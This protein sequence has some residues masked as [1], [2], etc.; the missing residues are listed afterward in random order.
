MGGFLST[1]QKELTK[2]NDEMEKMTDELLKSLFKRV[3]ESLDTFYEQISNSAHDAKLLPI[4]RV[5]SK[6]IFVRAVTAT[7][8]QDTI[9]NIVDSLVDTFDKGPSAKGIGQIAKGVVS[10][11]MGKSKGE[12]VRDQTYACRLNEVNGLS[13]LDVLFLAYNTESAS[14]VQRTSTVIGCCVVS[15]SVDMKGL[16][17]NTLR[18]VTGECFGSLPRAHQ[19]LIFADFYWKV[20]RKTD[21]KP[22]T[23]EEKEERKTAMDKIEAAYTE[24]DKEIAEKKKAIE[25][26]KP[27]PPA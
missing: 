26:A 2:P 23:D 25:A 18:V 15:S 9:G 24:W 13:R 5:V 20:M 6:K 17:D 22:L 21:P 4:D 16:N 3:E 7:D 19:E 27:H 11:L 12:M 14:I 1:L 8:T 10:M